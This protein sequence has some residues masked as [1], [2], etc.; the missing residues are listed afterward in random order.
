MDKERLFGV[1]EGFSE[2]E[3]DLAVDKQKNNDQSKGGN[4]F[5]PQKKKKKAKIILDSQNQ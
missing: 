4:I 2:K 5:D 1:E 3:L